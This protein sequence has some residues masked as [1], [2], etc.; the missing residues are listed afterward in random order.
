M[1]PIF[2]K[3]CLAVLFTIGFLSGILSGQTGQIHGKVVDENNQPVFGVNVIVK[4]TVLG[5]ATNSD[6]VFTIRQVPSGN[7]TLEVYYIGYKELQ[8]EVDIE[9]AEYDVGTIK[10]TPS[11]ISSEP[12]VVTASKYE[13]RTQDI[14]VSM[15]TLSKKDLSYRNSITVGDALKYVSGVNMNSSQVNIR[16]SSGY[17]YSVGSRVLLLLDGV[18]FI[19]GDTGEINFE[20]IPTNLIE[21]V[22]ILKGA[23]SAL[24]GSNALGGVINV[25]TKDISSTPS[26]YAKFYGGIYSDPYYEEWKWSD[27]NRYLNGQQFNYSQKFNTVGLM[28]GGSRFEDDSYKQN[29]WR[30]RYSGDGKLEW[31]ISPYQQLSLSGNYMWQ[32]RASFIF[33]RNLRKALQPPADQLNDRVESKRSYLSGSYRYILNEDKYL[34]IS[35]IWYRNQF[36]D[37]TEDSG[38]RSVSNNVDGEIQFVTQVR[39]H[40]LTAGATGTTSSVDSDIFGNRYANGAAAYLQDEI[41]WN[42]QFTTTI[43]ARFDYADVEELG[44][45]SRLNPKFGMVLKPYPGTAL[46]ASFGMGFRAPSLAEAFTTT[47]ISGIR[48]IPNTDNLKSERSVSMEAGINQMIGAWLVFD[49]SAFHNDFWDLVEPTFAKYDIQSGEFLIQFRNITRAQIRGVESKIDSRFFGNF[50][51]LSLGYTYMDP[52]NLETNDYLTFRPRH[53]FY[54]SGRVNVSVFQL[55]ADYRYISRYD[56]IDELFTDPLLRIFIPDLEKRVEAHIVDLRLASTFQLFKQPV[57]ISFQANNIFQY[58]YVEAVG[59]IA[60]IRHFVVT[61]ETGL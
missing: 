24:Y 57:R 13:Q 25:I 50:L 60:P 1:T 33:W 40:L 36:E 44:S 55:G 27:H 22:E 46:R 12:I 58:N 48:V 2:K 54:G 11:A 38:N 59:V 51:N 5:S 41:N 4:G 42:T 20:S 43:G 52:R 15:A 18:P 14:S 35:G 26:L 31:E 8:L 30:R 56:R 45:D 34:K 9:Q 61:F 47:N 29:D 6:G 21:R 39:R 53:L 32:E 3:Y 19:T 28:I 37:N 10:L 7:L 49:I 17:S 23:G 16:G